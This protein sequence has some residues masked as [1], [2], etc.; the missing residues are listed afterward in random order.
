MTINKFLIN[1]GIKSNTEKITILQMVQWVDE[2]QESELKKLRLDAVVGR[3]E[4]LVCPH[5]ATRTP[6][7]EKTGKCRQCGRDIKAN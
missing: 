1:K 7:E 6:N 4:L 2:W 5:Q 3:S